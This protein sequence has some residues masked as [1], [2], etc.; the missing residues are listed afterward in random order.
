MPTM[1]IGRR[2][3]GGFVARG[4]PYRMQHAHAPRTCRLSAPGRLP[5]GMARKTAPIRGGARG[6]AT[7][8]ETQGEA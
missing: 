8:R 7:W 4:A 3:V 2:A 6:G 1:V 5:S